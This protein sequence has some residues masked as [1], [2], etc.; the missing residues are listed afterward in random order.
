MAPS[1]PSSCDGGFAARLPCA[2]VTRRSSCMLRVLVRELHRSPG[3]GA[4]AGR[5]FLAHGATAAQRSAVHEDPYRAGIELACSQER[6]HRTCLLR[7]P[8]GTIAAINGDG[9]TRHG[10]RKEAGRQ[11]THMAHVFIV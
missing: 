8:P 4:P 2:W 7:E 5:A 11:A 9:A 1:D 6:T 3:I 10:A